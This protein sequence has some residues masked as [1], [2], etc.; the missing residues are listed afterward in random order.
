V[1]PRVSVIVPVYNAERTIE[2]TLRSVLDQQFDACE[3]IAVDD[4]STDSSF[5]MLNAYHDQVT[6]LRQPNRGP[7]A[8]RNAGAKVAAG[9][10]L[11]F[12][13][14]DDVWLPAKLKTSVDQLDLSSGVVAVYSD[15][16]CN[17]GHIINSMPSS[18]SLNDLLNCESA[19][20]PSAAVVRRS[21]F[22]ECGGFS[23]EFEKNDFGEDTFFAL[24]LREQGEFIHI[25]KPLVLYNRSTSSAALAK[26]PRGYRTLVRLVTK[27]YGRRGIGVISHAHRYYAS[28]LVATAL[29]HIKSKPLSIVPIIYLLK[30]VA[31]SPSYIQESILGVRTRRASASR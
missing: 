17:D 24:Q 29:E 16:L 21:A 4:G 18:P 25:A 9:E 26:Y 12:L 27:R 3:I 15:V 11:A 14:A 28:L 31:V 19:L 5:S 2:R 1:K 30:A 22:E 13:D 7:G 8:A 10:Y 20:Y 23:P 6:T